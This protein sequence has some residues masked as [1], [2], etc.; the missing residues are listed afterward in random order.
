MKAYYLELEE[1]REAPS[2]WY[3]YN[4]MRAM[5]GYYHKCIYTP[6]K[7]LLVTPKEGYGFEFKTL[8]PQLNTTNFKL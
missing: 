5:G 1:D 7:V 4:G 6:Q 8:T 2:G 3:T